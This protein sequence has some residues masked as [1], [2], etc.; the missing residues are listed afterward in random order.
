MASEWILYFMRDCSALHC[1]VSFSD[2]CTVR[3][4]SVEMQVISKLS[5]RTPPAEE[6][7]QRL[8][9]VAEEQNVKWDPALFLKEIR[10]QLNT[11]PPL[12]VSGTVLAVQR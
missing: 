12:T 8:Q 5:V 2:E 3:Y 4:R 9:K 7:L 11:L 6:K 1:T 10:D